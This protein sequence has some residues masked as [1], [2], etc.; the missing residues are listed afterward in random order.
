MKF[1]KEDVFCLLNIILMYLMV[2]FVYYPRHRG[3]LH[4]GL[5]YLYFAAATAA[6]LSAWR[7]IRS[8]NVPLA[9]LILVQIGLILHDIGGLSLFG[10]RTYELYALGIPYDKIVHFYNSLAGLLA[11]RMF[12]CG[13][14]V[15]LSKFE[16][17]ILVGTVMGAGALVE[18]IEY[19]GI[20]TLPSSSAWQFSIPLIDLYDNNL[21]DMVANCVGSLAA[22]M[23]IAFEMRMPFLRR[24]PA[25]NE[26]LRG[27]P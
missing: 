25:E 12:L 19:I 9:A 16:L 5:V 2:F 8:W 14:G 15:K 22:A 17:P 7:L 6:L 10:R 11:L 21:G 27:N 4:M 26:I 24:V 23:L 3:Q 20:R 18:V 13:M 1:R